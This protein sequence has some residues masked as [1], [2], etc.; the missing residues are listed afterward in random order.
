MSRSDGLSQ[1]A[2]RKPTNRKP[3]NQSVPGRDA[4][5]TSRETTY[6]LYALP[7]GR[8]ALGPGAHDGERLVSGDTLPE[9]CRC[10]LV[11]LVAAPSSEAAAFAAQV[12]RYCEGSDDRLS[13]LHRGRTLALC[14]WDGDGSVERLNIG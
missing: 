7:K 12:I 5:A 3:A 13:V 14:Y 6:G 2:N 4:V 11:Q 10:G 1:S 8:V 9:G